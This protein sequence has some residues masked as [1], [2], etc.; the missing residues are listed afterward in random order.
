MKISSA[1]GVDWFEIE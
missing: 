1:L